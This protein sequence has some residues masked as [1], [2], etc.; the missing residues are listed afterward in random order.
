VTILSLPGIFP[1]TKGRKTRMFK[2]TAVIRLV[3]VSVCLAVSGLA[4]ADLVTH[5]NY[6]LNISTNIVIHTDGTEWLQWDETEGKSISEAISDYASDGWV[7][8]GN[9][10]MNALF[11]DFGWT[12]GSDENTGYAQSSS[13]TSNVDDSA[14]DKFIELFGVTFSVSGG[15]PLVW[16]GVFGEGVESLR[17]TSATFG[18]DLDNDERYNNASVMSDYTFDSQW[19]DDKVSLRADTPNGDRYTSKVEGTGIA[20]V[21]V[22]SVSEPASLAIF[23]LGIMGLASRRFKKQPKRQER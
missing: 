7:L 3:V 16:G 15:D 5:N 19:D 13:F 6:T 10:Q 23:A 9:A 18:N 4:N 21:R 11:T 2:K 12:V 8:A 14:M 1:F 22:T 17:L 20:L